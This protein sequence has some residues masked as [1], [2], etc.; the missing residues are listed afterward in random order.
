M[1]GFATSEGDTTTEALEVSAAGASV[2]ASSGMVAAAAAEED[3]DDADDLDRSLTAMDWLPKLNAKEAGPE[4]DVDMD[5]T[6]GTGTGHGHGHGHGNGVGS[7]GAGSAFPASA[8][9]LGDVDANGKPPY[10]YMYTTVRN[11][12]KGGR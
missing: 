5:L 4:T 10:R 2:A 12:F 1:G 6:G 8:M 11:Q 7:G 9:Q 3:D